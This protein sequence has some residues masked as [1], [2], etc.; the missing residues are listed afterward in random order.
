M[1]ELLDAERASSEE[2]E[3]TDELSSLA[4]DTYD[5]A[6]GAETGEGGGVI[7]CVG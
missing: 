2:E 7:S 6:I 1:V 5:T 4:S 3:E